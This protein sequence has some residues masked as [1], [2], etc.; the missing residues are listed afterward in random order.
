MWPPGRYGVLEN[1]Q[2]RE[3]IQRNW[4]CHSKSVEEQCNTRAYMKP[5]WVKVDYFE[6]LN[7]L[8]A[9]NIKAILECNLLFVLIQVCKKV[10]L[11]TKAFQR[12]NAPDLP[13]VPLSR[14]VCW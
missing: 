6:K 1:C 2:H 7:G 5:F 9:E 14:L 13:H 12:M 11:I 10:C 4:S 8:L 3:S